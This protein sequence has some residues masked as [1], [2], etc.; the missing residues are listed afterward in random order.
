[1]NMLETD[2]KKYEFDNVIILNE[3]EIGQPLLFDVGG[4]VWQTSD[5]EHFITY[6]DGSVSVMTK[7]SVYEFSANCRYGFQPR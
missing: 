2:K 3:I 5:V 1:M 7:N 6:P 4:N